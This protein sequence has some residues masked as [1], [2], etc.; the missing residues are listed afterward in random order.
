MEVSDRTRSTPATPPDDG[1][2]VQCLLET[3]VPVFCFAIVPD[4]SGQGE[5]DLL[6]LRR[7]GGDSQPYGVEPFG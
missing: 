1:S 5:L 3:D 4:L 7:I 6:V 2:P